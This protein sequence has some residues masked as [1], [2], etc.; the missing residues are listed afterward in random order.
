MGSIHGE[1]CP[2]DYSINGAGRIKLVGVAQRIG[3]CGF[4]IGAVIS[5]ATSSAARRAVAE[6]YRILDM[7]FDPVTF[8]ALADLSPDIDE[9][10]LRAE[11]RAS[12][13][14]LFAA[15]G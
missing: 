15:Q 3:R 10:T 5:V 13:P 11:L 9:D 8:G 6:A 12:I 7:P 2:G 4:H 1:Y 14:E